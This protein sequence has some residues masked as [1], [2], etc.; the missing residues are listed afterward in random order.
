LKPGQG[1]NVGRFGALLV[2]ILAI[3]A[4]TPFTQARE[5]SF[6]FLSLAF[7]AVLVA[8]VYSASRKPRVLAVALLIGAPALAFEWVSNYYTTTFTVVTNLVLL[9]TFV[10]FVATVI[11]A[12]VLNESEVSLDTIFGGIAIYLLMGLGWAV[13]FAVIEHLEP[14]SFPMAGQDLQGLREAHEFVFPELL[15]F[16]FVTLT[17]LG[18]GDMT[19]TTETARTFAIFEAIGGQLYVAIFIARL[20]ALHTSHQAQ[21]SREK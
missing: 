13:G 20:V 9:G 6:N 11:L 12:Q 17:T 18:Y 3:F 21:Q 5:G 16:S 19:P 4:A 10:A 2:A 1:R 14:G 15:Y 8:G 7:S